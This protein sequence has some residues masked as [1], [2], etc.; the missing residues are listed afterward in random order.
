VNLDIVHDIQAV[1]RK[2]LNSMARPGTVESL[3]YE[4]AK[5][6]LDMN[7]N[8]CTFLNMLMLLD[9]EVS[10]NIVSEESESI[11]R[12]VGQMTYAQA[13]PVREAD[14]I[15]VLEDSRDKALES[16]CK[17]AKTGD[18]LNPNKSATI[19]AEFEN[20]EA[21]GNLELK[22][23][24]IK[25]K[26][27]IGI[28]GSNGWLEARGVKNQEFPMGVDIICLDRKSNLLCIPRTTVISR[29]GD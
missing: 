29:K 16:V 7:F 13:K 3:E 18:L 17:E 20:I 6:D 28:S 4:A 26:A 22:G 10:F 5:V 9:S 8:K 15:F 1:Y 11:T 27:E 2:A 21:F 19:I 24:G 14:F 12:F 25:K 23:P